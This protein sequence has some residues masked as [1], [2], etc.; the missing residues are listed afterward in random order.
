MRVRP[1]AMAGGVKGLAEVEEDEAMLRAA[2]QQSGGLAVV[3]RAAR[4]KRCGS[5]R[6]LAAGA[7]SRACAVE[8]KQAIVVEMMAAQS[9]A[10][11]M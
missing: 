9:A 3:A 8:P 10:L 5:R 1:G 4:A 7:R 11:C 2:A 6:L